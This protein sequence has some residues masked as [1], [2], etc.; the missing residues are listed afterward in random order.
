MPRRQSRAGDGRPA[1]I[2]SLSDCGVFRDWLQ[3]TERCLREAQTAREIAT[4]LDCAYL[5]SFFWIDWEG[6]VL[7]AKL[8]HSPDALDTFASGFFR[9]LEC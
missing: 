9:L 2:L 1:G 4:V 7:R 5:G 6:A 8:E 3:R